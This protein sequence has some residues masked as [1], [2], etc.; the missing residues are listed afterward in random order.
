MS[1]VPAVPVVDNNDRAPSPSHSQDQDVDVPMPNEPYHDDDEEQQEQE[2]R[3]AQSEGEED[4]QQ[5]DQQPRRARLHSQNSYEASVVSTSSNPPPY[6]LYPPAKTV[7]GRAFNWLRKIPRW[8]THQAIYLPTIHN[9]SGGGS[10]SGR[11][12]FSLRRHRRTDSSASS[13]SSTNSV[14]CWSYYYFAITDRLPDCPRFVLPS[15]L[16]Q[17]RLGL[18]LVSFFSL[19]LF[20]FLLFCSVYFQPT[21]Y[22]DPVFPDKT[23][24]STARFLTLNIFMR[25]P[26]IKNNWSDYKD[27]RLAYIEKYILPDYD[28]ITFQESFAFATRRKDRLITTARL[29]GYNY[30]I[31]SP[32]KYPWNIGVDG[33]LLMISRF[34]IKKSNIIEYPRGQHSDWLSIKGALHALIELNP[35]RKMHLY[36][37]H[38]QASYDLNNIIN[39][40]DTAIRLSQFSL[41]HNFVYDTT[42]DDSEPI[43]IVGD[44]NVDAA[45][46]PKDTPITR[47]SKESSPEYTKMVDVIRGT[48]VIKRPGSDER[49]FDHPW[50]MDDLKDVVYAKYGYHPV[51]FGD[52]TTDEEGQLIPAETV[53]TNW[54]QLMTVQSIDR[55]FWSDR[56]SNIIQLESPRVEKFWVKENSQMTEKERQ[57]TGFTQISDHYGLSC[58]IQVL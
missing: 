58:N 27:D 57:E 32:R 10:S 4:E 6:E 33:G 51:T 53:L 41:L 30:H 14:S 8:N 49:W 12:I 43:M 35:D 20:S 2:E 9:T 26:L 47:P 19:A 48:G 21:S 34:P 37:T 16:A 13:I 18:I 25:P 46:H 36:T 55:I 45:V 11:S 1:S 56:N 39:E 31:E 3:P 7:F 44:L 24:N 40:D 29:M 54:D 15:F 52:Y 5:H 28:V 22:P 42:K 23:T 38:T 50:K 17:H